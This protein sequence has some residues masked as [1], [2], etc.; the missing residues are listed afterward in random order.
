MRIHK[1]IDSDTEVTI[2]VVASETD[3]TPIKEAT[4]RHLG[5]ELKLAGFRT[6]KAPL[7]LVEKN[8][9]PTNLQ[10]EF[11]ERSI[12]H[13]YTQA[14]K[15]E[16]LRPVTNPQVAIKK[17]VPYTTLEFD[18][19]IEVISEIKLADYKKIRKTMPKA[20]VS[21]KDIQGVITS[22]RQRLAAKLPVDR[23]T[24]DGDEV[25]IDFVGTD[26]QGQ[27][28]NG[29][30][31][32]D[33]PLILGSNTFI[34]GFE[35][36]L[37]GLK[38]GEA[39]TFDIVF[40]KDYQVRALAN[41]TVTFQVNIKAVN[42]LQPAEL[43]DAFAAKAGPFKTVQELKEDIR[44]QLTYEA[45]AELHKNF[46]GELINEIAAGSRVSLPK[47]LVDD[48]INRNEEEE[49]RNLTHRGQTWQEHL[50]EEGIT[51]EE[52]RERQRPK[53]VEMIK[54]SLVLSE[55]ANREGI[56]VTP[57]ELEIRIT[58]LKG[59]YTDQAMRAELDK[60]ENRR[61]IEARLHAEKTLERLVSYT[62]K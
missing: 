44:K 25:I 48:Q 30:S 39:K 53:A 41:Q 4:L 59:Q 8:I 40:P 35:P 37:M 51:A 47:S 33:Y 15:T 19:K 6:G 58:I 14:I 54:N 17:F 52:H 11:L 29:A 28:I 34:P 3:L 43:N 45:Q 42:E 60:E 9:S 26:K 32:Q 56:T 61:E 50:D 55:I 13:L 31:A 62:T 5:Q 57:E 16:T 20:K 27:A 23:A 2:S 10:N 1:T 21:E 49:R 24:K 18:A 22:L 36:N 7:N 12:N 38:S 46:E